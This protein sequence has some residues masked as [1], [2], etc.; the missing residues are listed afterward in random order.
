MKTGES[1]VPWQID[2]ASVGHRSPELSFKVVN[3]S[4]SYFEGSAC[5]SHVV[6][7]LNNL[8]FCV[9]Y[10]LV[11]RGIPWLFHSAFNADERPEFNLDRVPLLAHFACK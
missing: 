4:W 6:F 10:G 11:V 1:R 8:A 5:L 9:I 7:V 2:Y 3:S